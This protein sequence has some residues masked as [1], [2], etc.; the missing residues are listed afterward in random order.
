MH[1]L[2]CI[3]ELLC[4]II[5]NLDREDR[6]RCAQVCQFWSEVALDVIWYNVE[7]LRILANPISPIKRMAAPGLLTYQ[8]VRISRTLSTST[9]NLISRRIVVST[10]LVYMITAP[11]SRRNTLAAYVSSVIII[12]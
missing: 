4:L 11:V 8:F 10:C 2:F 9:H 1:H 7:D 6:V 12:N 5:G 3:P